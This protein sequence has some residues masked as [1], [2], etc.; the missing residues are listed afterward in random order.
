MT[1]RLA[2]SYVRF[3]TAGQIEGDSIRRQTE[4]TEA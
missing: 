2:I 4:A 1:P 3:S